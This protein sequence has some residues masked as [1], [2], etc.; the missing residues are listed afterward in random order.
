M[1]N[2]STLT[3]FSIILKRIQ[4]KFLY[5][6]VKVYV[7]I[8]LIIYIYFYLIL[9]LHFF[10]KRPR[11]HPGKVLR[12]PSHYLCHSRIDGKCQIA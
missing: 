11:P 8:Y 12:I 5:M 10:L 9:E 1:R 4:V 2:K 6:C 7:Y 3:D